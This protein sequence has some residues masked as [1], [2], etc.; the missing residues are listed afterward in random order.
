MTMAKAKLGDFVLIRW[1]DAWSD[2]EEKTVEEFEADCPVETVGWLVRSTPDVVSLSPERVR[3][4]W[5]RGTT[6]IPRAIVKDML[7]L[8]EVDNG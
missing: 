2:N 4:N 7:V 3:E 1:V 6:H 8:V 5:H